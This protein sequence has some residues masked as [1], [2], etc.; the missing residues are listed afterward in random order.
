MQ[1]DGLCVGAHK[2]EGP[3][4]RT[5][6]TYH[7]MWPQRLPAEVGQPAEGGSQGGGLKASQKWA[8]EGGVMLL[9]SCEGQQLAIQESLRN[10]PAPDP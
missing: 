4:W 8:P 10:N 3:E 9:K 2:P 1:G 7:R 5:C 6:L